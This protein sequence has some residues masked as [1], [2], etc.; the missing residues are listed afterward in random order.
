[1]LAQS[2]S[3]VSQP[4]VNM[5]MGEQE[6]VQTSTAEVP[7]KT[8]KC[9]IFIAT[10][11]PEAHVSYMTRRG[12]RIEVEGHR[13]SYLTGVLHQQEVMSQ[14]I[15]EDG[16]YHYAVC[17]DRVQ[18]T[19]T[20]KQTKSIQ[21]YSCGEARDHEVGIEEYDDP[22][23]EWSK[24]EQ[25]HIFAKDSSLP[26]VMTF[27]AKKLADA[28]GSEG[29]KEREGEENSFK[30]KKRT[31]ANRLVSSTNS[32]FAN[33]KFHPAAGAVRRLGSPRASIQLSPYASHPSIHPSCEPHPRVTTQQDKDL[34]PTITATP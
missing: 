11:T 3:V 24:R 14:V 16:C 1:M 6:A 17:V 7:I 23:G 26:P 22:E 33:L 32:E 18:C 8:L 30:M 19:V 29:Q 10:D 15:D 28:G 25:S 34:L 12:W 31:E 13:G 20:E 4:D 21:P 5:Q 2:S 27:D 9:G